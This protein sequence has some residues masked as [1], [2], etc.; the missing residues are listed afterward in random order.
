M[1][2]QS[3]GSGALVLGSAPGRLRLGSGEQSPLPHSQAGER[4]PC[5]SASQA[6]TFH[7]PFFL[8]KSLWRTSASPSPKA[9][10]PA[11]THEGV[12]QTAWGRVS[13]PSSDAGER[14]H[15]QPRLQRLEPQ[16]LAAGAQAQRGTGE[17][18]HSTEHAFWGERDCSL[19]V[20]LPHIWLPNCHRH[21]LR[22]YEAPT[23]NLGRA[24]LGSEMLPPACG[25]RVSIP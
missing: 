23:S 6:A 17:D 13:H 3:L 22:W 18:R 24:V 12:P 20:W 15:G 2:R 11:Q 10:N 19:L 8:L 16:L 9:H 21:P 5:T 25:M 1:A 7:A 4:L 14:Q